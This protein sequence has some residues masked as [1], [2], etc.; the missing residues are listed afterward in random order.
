M[1][2]GLRHIFNSMLLE[3]TPPGLHLPILVNIFGKPNCPTAWLPMNLGIAVV[4]WEKREKI[5]VTP[6]E[7]NTDGDALCFMVKT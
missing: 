7:T 6:T 4:Q 5:S 1:P 3:H 2:F